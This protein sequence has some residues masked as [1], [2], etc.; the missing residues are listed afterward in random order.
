MKA[1]L[2]RL[3]GTKGGTAAL[4]I[5]TEIRLNVDGEPMEVDLTNTLV[6]VYVEHAALAAAVF[7][8]AEV[9]NDKGCPPGELR[10]ARDN[11]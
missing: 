7:E 9:A 10:D 5:A 11:R 2:I 3:L 4:D 8:G 1:G 6:R